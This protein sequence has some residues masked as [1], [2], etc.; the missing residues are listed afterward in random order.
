MTTIR[1]PKLPNCEKVPAKCEQTV[2]HTSPPNR[3][4]V[5]LSLTVCRVLT[6]SVVQR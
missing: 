6:P 3:G 2:R 5:S 4:G 1:H